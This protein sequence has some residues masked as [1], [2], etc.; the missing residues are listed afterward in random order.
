M[1]RTSSSFD[2]E[3]HRL[4]VS[5]ADGPHCPARLL[6]I[7]LVNDR[8]RRPQWGRE[9]ECNIMDT[10]SATVLAGQ[11]DADEWLSDPSSGVTRVDPKPSSIRRIKG[12]GALNMVEYWVQL[13]LDIG[14]CLVT[15]TDVPILRGHRGLILG[16][17]FMGQGRVSISYSTSNRGDG[18]LTI[19]D[20]G[21]NAIS[22]PVPFVHRPSRPASVL[23]LAAV[24]TATD[25]CTAHVASAERIA[26]D[27][28]PISQAE[29]EEFAK[30]VEEAPEV[31][32]ALQQVQPVAWAPETITVPAWSQAIVEVKVPE[33]LMKCK[34]ILLM[35][36]EDETEADLGVLVAPALVSVNAKGTVPCQVINLGRKPVRIPLLRRLARFQVDPRVYSVQ[37]EK[38]TEEIINEIHI[39]EDLTELDIQNLRAM[40]EKRRAL[41]RTR[42][43]LAHGYKMECQLNDPSAKPSNAG[44]RVRPPAEEE[45]L[46]EWVRKQ[47]QEGIVE[48]ARSPYNANPMLVK[49]PLKPGKPQE[50]RVVLDMRALNA[51]L[52]KDVYPLP[53]LD[54][55]LNSLGK[56]NWFSTL[57]LLQGFHQVEVAEE[58]KPLLAFSCSM[59]QFQ[60]VRMPMGLASSPSCFMRLVDATLRGLPPGIALAYVDDVCV[61]TQG[62]FEDHLRDVGMVFDKLIEGGFG[63]RCDKV[64]IGMREVPYLGFMVGAFGTRPQESKVAPILE[65]AYDL[66]LSD[67][68]NAPARFAGMLGFYSKFIPNLNIL[69]APFHELRAK[70]AEHLNIVGGKTKQGW[71]VGSLRFRAAFEAAKHALASIT[72]LRRADPSKKFYIDVDAASSCGIGAALMQLDDESDP[73]SLA[74]VAFWSRRLADEERGYSV[75]D[76]ECLGLSDALG[77]WRPLILSSATTVRTDHHSLQWLLSSNHPD[78]SRVAGWA[79]KAQEFQVDIT[80]IP[81]KYNVVADCLSRAARGESRGMEDRPCIQDRLEQAM[82]PES[83]STQS[84]NAAEVPHD[85]ENFP[86]ASPLRQAGRAALVIMRKNNKGG[87]EVLVENHMDVVTFPCVT[88]DQHSTSFSYRQ[89]VHAMIQ[90]VYETSDSSLIRTITRGAQKFRRRPNSPVNTH[91]LV[92]FLRGGDDL[93]AIDGCSQF[94]SVDELQLTGSD[95]VAFM[96]L[97]RREMALGSGEIPPTKKH[98]VGSFTQL[99]K[100]AAQVD[101]PSPIAACNATDAPE[102]A[103]CGEELTIHSRP[104]G[105]AL[106]EDIEDGRLAIARI[107]HRLYKYPGISMAI[108]LEGNL[109]GPRSH[110]ALMQISVDAQSSEEQQ[111]TFVFDT[112]RQ[113]ASFL[114]SGPLRNILEDAEVPK[115][116]HCCYGDCA[117]LYREY[118]IKVQHVFDTGLADCI[119]R[120]RK[121][122]NQRG[123]EKVLDSFLGA[124]CVTMQY[125]GTLIHEVG[126]WERRPLTRRLFTYA[127]E[128]VTYCNQL[129]SAMKQSL[130]EVGLHELVLELSQLRA[131][132]RALPPHS[133]AYAPPKYVV[134]AVNDGRHMVC[135]QRRSDGLCQLPSAP[136]TVP[137]AEAKRAALAMWDEVMG[138]PPKA[139]RAAIRARLR[140]AVRIGDT[141]LYQAQIP[142]CAA[143][144]DSIT[145]TAVALGNCTSEWR[146]VMRPVCYPGRPDGSTV[147][148]QATLFQYMHYCNAGRVSAEGALQFEYD[149]NATCNVVVGK[150]LEKNRVALV[151]HDARHAY[152]LANSKGSPLGFISGPVEI[153]ASPREAVIKAFDLYAGPALRKYPGGTVGC[154]PMPF[155]SKVVREALDNLQEIGV[156]GNVHYFSCYL[157]G[158]NT[159]LKSAFFAARRACNGFRLTDQLHKRHPGFE[160]TTSERAL[161]L[162]G[163][164]DAEALNAALAYTPPTTRGFGSAQWPGI[165]TGRRSLHVL[166]LHCKGWRWFGWGRNEHDPQ[167]AGDSPRR[168]NPPSRGLLGNRG[169]GSAQWPR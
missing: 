25:E 117:T 19:R 14:G 165:N 9:V 136:L 104:H 90:Q 100:Q 64:H 45:A 101:Q 131:P 33:V 46:C 143:A 86:R 68:A 153:G 69:L 152:F 56:A 55:N 123:L 157:S 95:D 85:D 65:M 74:P 34:N 154:N 93:Q 88:T 103:A 98:W 67:P 58:S 12:I 32:K 31:E 125:K 24:A 23:A 106:C 140:K 13:T 92:N 26:A 102:D 41:F 97:V 30:L 57:D 47:Q 145:E 142:D 77:H 113:G 87:A 73:E 160:I 111:L 20:K 147:K 109:G 91:Y 151:L 107:A 63:V 156:Y 36:L 116:L 79:S 10:G 40:L 81:G 99:L 48:P 1:K 44:T 66:M 50:Y 166:H 8:G 82:K 124:D 3:P 62:S 27:F 110:I 161:P 159:E 83:D 72:A 28:G 38:T 96:Q 51:Q 169:F 167:R 16:N 112:H 5:S 4:Q 94:V 129:Y 59:G 127:Y 35:P 22:L 7:S 120:Y 75:R 164:E 52:R 146:V 126:L 53:N 21:L 137:I 141:L 49:K 71:A 130:E 138:E 2:D 61:A 158:L 155:A 54:T 114:G 139:I 134:I 17:D 70:G 149:T 15:F 108:D 6:G 121:V 144:L 150:T 39:G 37:Y 11:V 43:C 60:Y 168:F 162:L 89:Q 119:L 135:I 18:T 76:Q 163:R 128:D 133:P 115:V 122:N 42:L 132:P 78:G 118:G 29:R 80:F 148:A 105:P 84:V